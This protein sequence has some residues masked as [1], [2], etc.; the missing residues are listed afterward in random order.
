MKMVVYLDKANNQP[1]NILAD[2]I[3][4]RDVPCF[5]FDVEPARRYN[6]TCQ[7]SLRMEA[8]C[9]ASK[10]NISGISELHLT[11][12]NNTLQSQ[13]CKCDLQILYMQI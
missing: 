6:L 1:Q 8:I 12:Y 4:T 5:A 10:D 3:Q 13:M 7:Q 9:I 2:P 11:N